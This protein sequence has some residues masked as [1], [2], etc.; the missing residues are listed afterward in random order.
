M[1]EKEYLYYFTLER[2]DRL[3]YSHRL[4]RGRIVRFCVQYEAWIEGE[5]HPIVRY[6]SA[7]GRPHK[8]ILHPDR[9]QDK[10]EFSGYSREE[11]LTLVIVQK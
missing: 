8:D 6:D 5:W 1:S 10:V 2:E 4:T 9:S 11:V 3:R 7:H